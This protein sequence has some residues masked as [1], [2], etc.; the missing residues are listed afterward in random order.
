[1][2]TYNEQ[3]Q[4]IELRNKRNHFL[5]LQEESYDDIKMDYGYKPKE[6]DELSE[7]ILEKIK[8]WRKLL[9]F[10]FIIEEL[11]NLGWSPNLLYDDNGHFAIVSDGFQNISIEDGPIDND[12]YFNVKKEYWKPTIREALNQYLDES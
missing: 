1:M 7:H 5:K 6:I 3:N 4:I 10:E 11:T 12:M 2:D 8:S 9:P